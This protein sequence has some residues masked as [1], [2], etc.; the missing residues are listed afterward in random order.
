MLWIGLLSVVAVFTGHPHL[1]SDKLQFIFLISKENF[2]CSF[3]KELFKED[4]LFEH[5]NHMFGLIDKKIFTF[6]R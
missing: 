3:S 1:L 4:N 5:Q 2:S 6:L